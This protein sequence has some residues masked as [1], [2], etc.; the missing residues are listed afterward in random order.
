MFKDNDMSDQ[1]SSFIEFSDIL[2][3]KQMVIKTWRELLPE[4]SEY[5]K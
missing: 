2:D 1:I 3:K 4:L 5:F